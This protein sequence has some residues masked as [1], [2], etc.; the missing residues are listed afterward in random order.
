MYIAIYQIDMAR[1]PDNVC[2]MDFERTNRIQGSSSINSSIYNKVFEGPVKADTLE[3]IYYIFNQQHPEGYTG[4]SLS[5]SDVVQVV[6]DNPFGSAFYFCDSFGFKRIDFDSSKAQDLVHPPVSKD[7]P[8]HLDARLGISVE[9]TREELEQLAKGGPDAQRL[10][11][12]L[13]H[14]DRCTMGGDTYFPGPWNPDY[15][16]D[17]LNFVLPYAPLHPVQEKKPSLD[18]QIKASQA[19]TPSQTADEKGRE[20][21]FDR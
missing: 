8:I 16:E 12:D 1:D 5:V 21:G 11:V 15:L 4:R 18:D 19:R 7:G 9:V 6:E 10:L 2:F 14:S 20:E 17:D 3:D 13:V